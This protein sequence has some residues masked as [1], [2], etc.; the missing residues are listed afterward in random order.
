M[1]DSRLAVVVLAAGKGTR[2]K[3]TRPKV[4]QPLAGRPLLRYVLDAVAPLAPA[5]EIV[6]IGPDMAAVADAAAPVATV[7]QEQQLGTGHAA[8][9]ACR[10]LDGFRR[11]G[12]HVLVVFGDTPLITGET[13]GALV[14]A[15]AGEPRPELVLLGFESAR[16]TG[17]GRILRDAAGR[18]TRIVEEKDASAEERKIT[19]CNGGLMLADAA[20]LPVLLEQVGSDNAKGEHYLT[21]LAG[22]AH[23]AG[24]ATAVVEGSEQE[25]MGIN[26]RA[27]L[28]AAEAVM[29]GRLR[30]R[31]MDQGAHLVDPSAVWL[32]ADTRLAPDVTVEPG[33][34]F[35]LGVT[36]DEGATIRAF[37]HLEGCRVGA[38]CTVG[39][40]ARLRPGTQL[41]EGARIGNFVETKN[42]EMGAGAKAN[43]LTYLG[44]ASVGAGANVGAGTITCNY[45]GFVKSRTEIGAGAF[46]GSN[47]ALVAPVKIGDGAYVGSGSVVTKDVPADALALGRVTQV[48][49][50]GWAARLRNL[51]ALTKKVPAGK[52]KEAKKPAKKKA[53]RR[54]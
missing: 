8:L 21:D 1:T 33:V 30:A 2:M 53:K 32:A 49:K 48:N 41:G 54:R 3:S 38:G 20:R 19:L 25:V 26:S 46:I 45:D 5:D 35:G 52:P 9:V 11:P 29:Q 7:V 14:A 47:S 10:A 24:L 36:V 12:D 4:L 18:P 27:E 22:L 6:V 40:F 50:P 28:A 31:A 34:V 39:P 17:Y 16:P 51:K 13:L 44:D 23:D 42:L 37:S 15:R 43:H